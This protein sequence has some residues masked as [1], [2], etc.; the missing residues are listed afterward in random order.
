MKK[1][2]NLLKNII[3]SNFGRLSSPS[4]VTF[5]L[6]YKCNLKC[7]TCNIWQSQSAGE[8]TILEIE[9]IFK[10]IPGLNWLD[11]TGGE[12]TFKE[13]SLDAVKVIIKNS[14]KLSI[15]HISSNGQLPDKLMP[16]VEAILKTGV[17][18]VVNISID[19]PKEINDEL[20]GGSDTYVKS[21]ESFNSLKKLKKGHYHLSCTI[22]KFNINYIDELFADLSKDIPGFSQTDIHFNVFHKSPHYYN[23]L[24]IDGLSGLDLGILNKYFGIH[25][26]M[27]LFKRIIED[28]YIKGIFVYL[29]TGKVRSIKCQALNSSC[30]INP[31]G[32]VYPC[33]IYNQTLGNLRDQDYD[34][35]RLWNNPEFFMVHGKIKEKICPDCWGACE[36]YSSIL[37]DINGSLKMA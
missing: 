28:R 33:L 1:S 5:A 31:Q 3:F 11:L 25:G 6:T 34:I 26:K 7:K 30:F 16:L 2:I 35:R 32:M 12:V 20:R 23:N 21:I 10:K 14:E 17:V 4:K 27:G 9:K 36:A 22:S 18:P 37:G 8:V 19:G 29:K 13:N 24:D 15:F